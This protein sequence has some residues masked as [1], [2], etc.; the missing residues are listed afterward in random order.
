MPRG[1]PPKHHLI[2]LLEGDRRKG[3]IRPESRPVKAL[4]RPEILDDVPDGAKAVLREI[5]SNSPDGLFAKCDTPALTAFA[6]AAHLHGVAAEALW[7][8]GGPIVDGRRN[9]W[10]QILNMQA[11][12]MAR[13]GS[14]LALDPL[15]RAKLRGRFNFPNL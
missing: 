6:M 12:T 10:L 13:H 8:T 14:G 9:P 11:A 2:R 5:I 15:S 4:G 7:R 1:R 3:P